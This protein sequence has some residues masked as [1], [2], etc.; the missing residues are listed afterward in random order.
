MR[1]KVKNIESMTVA[2]E[3][4]HG[5]KEKMKV[6]WGTVHVDCTLDWENTPVT[7]EN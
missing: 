6:Q 4:M 5:I 1:I 7:V 2:R 3:Q